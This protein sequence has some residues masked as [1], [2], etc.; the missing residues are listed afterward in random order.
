MEFLLKNPTGA[1]R[2]GVLSGSFNPITAA[3]VALAEAALGELDEVLLVMPRE[4]P[5]KVYEG[6]G[7]GERIELVRRAVDGRTGLS[8]A[9]SDG[10]LFVDIARECRD[11]YGYDCALWFLCGRDA[12]ERIVNWDYGAEGRFAEQLEEF[13]C[14]GV[15]R[16]NF[17]SEESRQEQ[18]IGGAEQQHG[19]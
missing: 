7:L 11:H 17:G 8:V 10:G 9:I 1:R 3:H 15:S 4:F 5:H 12:A 14:Q 18:H 2:L 13:Q 19:R 6:V 16:K